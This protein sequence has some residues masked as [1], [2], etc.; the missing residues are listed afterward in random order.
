MLVSTPFDA[1][2]PIGDGSAGFR[3]DPSGTRLACQRAMFYGLMTSAIPM[4]QGTGVVHQSAVVTQSR[5]ALGDHISGHRAHIGPAA[6]GL[7]GV[8]A[9][10]S[11]GDFVHVGVQTDAYWAV[12]VGGG[13]ITPRLTLGTPMANL[14]L[15]G[16]GVVMASPYA[17]GPLFEVTPFVAASVELGE[18]LDLHGGRWSIVGESHVVP[19]DGNPYLTSVVMG[20]WQREHLGVDAGVATLWPLGDDEIIPLPWMG[21]SYDWSN[22]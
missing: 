13:R 19:L 6:N 1:L 9:E 11:L 8:S 21:L 16:T 18:G 14:T 22:V 2:S 3:A 7:V 20:R 12:L 17:D 5:Y 10:R 15:G 4:P